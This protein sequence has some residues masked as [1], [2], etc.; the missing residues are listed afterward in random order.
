[1]NQN[2]TA[3]LSEKISAQVNGIVL[4]FNY[5]NNDT[6]QQTNQSWHTF[7]V[8]KNAIKIGSGYA[9]DFWMGQTN[10]GKVCGKALYLY[11][12]HLTGVTQNTASGTANGIT[13]ANSYYVLRYVFGV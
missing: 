8:P 5:Y 12:D 3:N 6:S 2:H 10:F 9:Y 1:M 13:Y 11:D 4:V 7:F